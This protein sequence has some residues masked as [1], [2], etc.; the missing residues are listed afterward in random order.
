MPGVSRR[1]FLRSV[2]ALV[3]LSAAGCGATPAPAAL[4]N[5][6]PTQASATS[7]TSV[8]PAS[9]PA[10]SAPTVAPLPTVTPAT[11]P[12]TQAS[13][14][15]LPPAPILAPTRQATPPPAADEAYMAV[16][17]GASPEAITRAAIAA[18]GGIQRFVKAG[19]DVIIK[20]NICSAS[21]PMEYAATTNPEVVA[22][23]V[24]LC[25]EAGAKRVRVMDSPFQ[26]T[27]GHAYDISGIEAA[28]KQAGGEM[29]L[30][31]RMKYQ[32]AAIPQGKDL[33]K[34]SVYQDAIKADVLINVPIAKNHGIARLTLGMKNQM[35][36]IMDRGQI[37]YNMG[38]RLA[39]LTSLLKPSLTV[40][41]AV[42]I[43]TQG[44][45]GYSTTVLVSLIYDEAYGGR[46]RMGRACA[47]SYILFVIV[48]I[49]TLLQMHLFK[50]KETTK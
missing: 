15:T 14:P 18:I 23:L 33:K 36:L 38:Q 27:D 50:E 4:P 30:M 3:V 7:P 25:R 28:V 16:A 35:G 17:H 2:A 12:P 34:W 46:F 13:S 43:L 41:D 19:N 26:G 44:G 9:A 5:P 10:T 49:F 32:D 40:I 22:T 31:A 29:E 37:H 6:S 39:D 8:P 42:R 47:I 1:S 48:L 11:K 24:K 45:P 21:F 20:P